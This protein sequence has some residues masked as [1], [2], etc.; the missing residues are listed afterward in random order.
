MMDGSDIPLD[1]PRAGTSQ[2][3]VGTRSG[4]AMGSVDCSQGSC[5]YEADSAAKKAVVPE[6]LECVCIAMQFIHVL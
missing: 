6:E 3:D 5:M 4:T 2:P 1:R